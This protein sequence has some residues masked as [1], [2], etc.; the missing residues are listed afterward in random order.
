MNR[1]DLYRHYDKDGNLLYVGIS[2]SALGRIRRCGDPGDF[3][4]YEKD[5]NGRNKRQGGIYCAY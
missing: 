4:R 5:R 1:C 3:G 2:L